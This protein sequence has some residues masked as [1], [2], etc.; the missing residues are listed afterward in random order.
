MQ[1]CWHPRRQ[2]KIRSVDFGICGLVHRSCRT[3]ARRHQRLCPWLR[4]CFPYCNGVKPLHETFCVTTRKS[5]RNVPSAVRTWTYL[6]VIIRQYRTYHKL[7]LIRKR[8]LLDVIIYG[9]EGGHQSA[10]IMYMLAVA[11][12]S[13]QSARLICCIC[14]TNQSDFF[15]IHKKEFSLTLQ[16]TW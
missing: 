11:T 15:L 2:V 9:S 4:R 7:C 12:A 1:D 13:H 16:P 3:M 6:V 8:S 14:A 5:L 10:Y